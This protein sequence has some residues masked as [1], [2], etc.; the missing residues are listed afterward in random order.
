MQA[1]FHRRHEAIQA[2]LAAGA[3]PNAATSEGDTA[4]HIAA[5]RKAP[6]VVHALLAGGADPSR[7]D[8]DG[9]TPL[10]QACYFGPLESVK[11]LVE[12]GVDLH[13]EAPAN[14]YLLAACWEGKADIAAYLVK[15]GARLDP[16]T[17]EHWDAL[18]MEGRTDTLKRL[19]PHLDI[20]RVRN[21]GASP[22]MVVAGYQFLAGVRLL[23]EHGA[24]LAPKESVVDLLEKL[25]EG[26]WRSKPEE[27]E[28]TVAAVFA[29]FAPAREAGPRLM[30]HAARSNSPE[31]VDQLAAA[32]LDV[33]GPGQPSPLAQHLD[34]PMI[35]ALLRNGGNPN[36]R[37]EEGVPV[38]HFAILSG[39]PKTV[40]LLLDAGADPLV[41]DTT[42][43]RAI[44]L[45]AL[46]DS[47]AIR[48]LFPESD[49]ARLATQKLVTVMSDYSPPNA[50]EVANLLAQGADPMAIVHKNRTCVLLA[51]ARRC[52][53][54]L[55]HLIAAGATLSSAADPF[56][57][58]RDLISS[59]EAPVFAAHVQQLSETL[60][61]EPTLIDGSGGFAFDLRD[62]IAAR[63]QALVDEGAN[64]TAAHLR[65][66]FDV[67]IELAARYGGTAPF[68][69][70][71]W[72][73]HPVH[74]NRLLTLPTDN[75]RAVMALIS[76]HAGESEVGIFEILEKLDAWEPLG[77]SL[78]GVGNDAFELRFERLP[79][80]TVAFAE[81]L[82]R[83]CPDLVD[84]G[85]ESVEAL[86][87]SV[88]ED[89][90]VSFWWD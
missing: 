69:T 43:L 38:L 6:K 40:K 55:D 65:A 76:P 81:E 47:K 57:A 23:I 42:G 83:F 36:G 14:P 85:F 34:Q 27:V 16:A 60:G 11:A 33:E 1:V 18:G 90:R 70:G 49:P 7:V 3:D 59:G 26:G 24:D 67:P 79:E 48:K 10:V 78:A 58:T 56:L 28:K 88:V 71:W 75:P 89:R 53:D 82:Y 86:R 50:D 35:E 51:A 29:R 87:R 41:A 61:I 20:R 8:E 63:E 68:W 5:R 12:A 62:P 84:Q 66:M 73:A 80:D 25:L 21:D 77:W 72:K 32:G 2:L 15:R 4:L 13:L 9:E 30:R 46:S 19:L 54:V 31:I 17:G 39:S 52:W 22:L 74:P 44:E 37:D 45:A 64:V